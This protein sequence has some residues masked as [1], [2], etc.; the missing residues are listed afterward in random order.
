MKGLRGLDEPTA[1]GNGDAG[2]AGVRQLLVCGGVGVGGVFLRFVDVLRADH[3]A[4]CGVHELEGGGCLGRWLCLCFVAADVRGQGDG[5]V[6]GGGLAEVLAQG[7]QV[8][9]QGH[10]GGVVGG[11]FCGLRGVAADEQALA[12]ADGTIGIGSEL[13]AQAA[14][15]A[16]VVVG[17]V[18][19]VAQVELAGFAAAGELGAQLA[20]GVVKHQL[21]VA[22]AAEFFAL[23]AA[24]RTRVALGGL[25]R[26][27]RM[28]G[29]GV[30]AAVLA[31]Q[32]GLGA[33][34]IEQRPLQA[35][36]GRRFAC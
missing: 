18:D 17:L 26:C 12:R 6:G 15:A 5:L 10:A 9:G 29:R 31:R 19:E 22:P 32:V 8:F 25:P 14:Q 35:T 33:Y 2:A 20:R 3:A 23:D 11:G 28:P 34:E 24:E 36:V 13:K 1:C 4:E 30:A 21:V 7:A 27:G 16:A